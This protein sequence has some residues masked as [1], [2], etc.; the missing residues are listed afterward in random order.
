MNELSARER[1]L[2]GLAA[3]LG[4]N[5]IPCVEHHIPVARKAGLSD[6]ELRAAIALADT[7]RQVPARRVLERATQ[8]LT[9]PAASGDG[10]TGCGL[11]DRKPVEQTL[12]AM[13][14]SVAAAASGCSPGASAKPSPAGGCC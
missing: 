6:D 5:C 4:S 1:A 2:V 10:V 11:L 9:A 14:S 13:A 12:D 7:V 3:A 8:L